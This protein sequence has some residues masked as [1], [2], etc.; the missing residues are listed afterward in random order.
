[1]NNHVRLFL[2]IS[3]GLLLLG[4]QPDQAA[5]Q[6][7]APPTTPE[8]LSVAPKPQ[9]TVHAPSGLNY[10]AAPQGTVL[11]KLEDGTPVAVVEHTGV[12]EEIM[13]AG[14]VRSGEWVG[15]AL[16]D[17]VV[18]VFDAFLR[19]IAADQTATAKAEPPT[20]VYMLSGYQAEI[21][22]RIR[23][24]ISLTHEYWEYSEVDRTMI[25]SAYLGNGQFP[26]YHYLKAPYRRR[27]LQSKGIRETDQ[28]FVY[29]YAHDELYT[30]PVADLP[31]LAHLS[32]Y[33]PGGAP[34]DY[35]IGFSLE[36][37]WPGYDGREI[38][39]TFVYVGAKN[40]FQTGQMQP[41]LWEQVSATQ[42][43]V[44]A[45]APLSEGYVGERRLSD[46]VYRF[47]WNDLTYWLHGYRVTVLSEAEV[48]FDQ[49]IYVGESAEF[50]HVVLRGEKP[51]PS[52]IS[53]W[54]GQLFKGAD[55]VMFGF[56][57]IKFGCPSI[58]RLDGS[59]K[60]VAIACDNR[61]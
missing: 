14:K 29:H 11:G 7:T 36:E 33:N 8:S 4:C 23:P 13:D 21:G 28:V 27:F 5:K 2:S 47:T 34:Q 37:K 35:L 46:S 26:E 58:R 12:Q 30:Y 43:P 57:Y 38:G 24:F 9:F 31:L 1:M 41:I 44:A 48:L 49:A 22:G 20:E 18:Y 17:S 52:S 6:S 45:K 60:T 25:D 61:H 3:L 51:Q 50:S 19:S 15:V 16:A 39:H 54:T 40:P 10:R 32:P 42:L 55:P 53:Q 59:G 56:Q